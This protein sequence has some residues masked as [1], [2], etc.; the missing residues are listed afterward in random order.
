MYLVV[1]NEYGDRKIICDKSHPNYNDMWEWD[2]EYRKEYYTGEWG[3]YWDEQILK[4]Y[5]PRKKEGR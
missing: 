1:E 5:K 4:Y 2:R 3:D